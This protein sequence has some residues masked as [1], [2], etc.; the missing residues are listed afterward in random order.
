MV[1]GIV[2]KVILCGDDVVMHTVVP[3]E[4]LIAKSHV[5]AGAISGILAV[6]TLLATV[7]NVY[8]RKI[9]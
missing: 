7:H 8:E 2:G 1:T 6:R 3:C 4:Q 5:G 9:R